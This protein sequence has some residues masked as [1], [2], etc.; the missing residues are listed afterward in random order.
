MVVNNGKKAAKLE[1]N[2]A[3]QNAKYEAMNER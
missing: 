3:K 2:R 1:A